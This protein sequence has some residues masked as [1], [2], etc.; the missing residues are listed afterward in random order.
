MPVLVLL[1]AAAAIW[2]RLMYRADYFPAFFDGEE[3][4]SLDMAR[5]ACG[6][7]ARLGSWW[8]VFTHGLRTYNKGYFWVMVPF[9]QRFGYDF[10]LIPWVLAPILSVL[11][12]AVLALHHRA[13]PRA[14]LLPVFPIACSAMLCVCVRRYKWH[15]VTFLAALSVYAFFMPEAI[16]P[17]RP[18]AAR[19]AAAGV[20]A[21][22][23]YLYFGSAIYL[24]PAAF[25]VLMPGNGRWPSRRRLAAAAAVLA[26]AT[27][28]GGLAALAH[29]IVGARI[30][31]QA[32]LL[33]GF[34]SAE[35]AS[36]RRHSLWEF[37]AHLLSIPFLVLLVLGTASAIRRRL[38]P[39]AWVS[40]V[41]FW[42]LFLAQL[43]IE[44]AD[45]PDYLTWSMIPLLGLLMMG[46]DAA[47]S[48][49]RLL[50]AAGVFA[51]AAL[52]AGL[53]VYELDRYPEAS[54]G[55]LYQPYAHSFNTMT[56]S[57]LA[58][59]LISEDPDGATDYYLPAPSVPIADGGFDYGVNLERAEFRG[60][61]RRIT[62]FSGEGDLRRRLGGR[63]KGR[64]A[65]VLESVSIEDDMRVNARNA[66]ILGAPAE[67]IVPYYQVYGMPFPLRKLKVPPNDTGPL[68]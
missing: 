38:E 43:L 10:R 61:L 8:E 42:S 52:A 37:G 49:L 2:L 51:A 4:R 13:Y 19:A 39:Y 12:G 7:A 29:P 68:R 57:A 45:N 58:L 41:L 67:L 24:L 17:A 30:A 54:R 59:R 21:L 1:M 6:E 66:R 9:Y 60:A 26:A 44:R 55:A 56:Q 31:N 28:F 15:S 14:S 65:V 16:W 36:I 46:G 63:D 33:R 22:S 53:C 27:L 32:G 3:A 47:V 62:Y 25:L 5:V 11:L 64:W 20:F 50:G 40:L 48:L 35:G 34:F 23:C 18:G